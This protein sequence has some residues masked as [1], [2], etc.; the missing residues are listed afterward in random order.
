MLPTPKGVGYWLPSLRDFSEAVAKACSS[1]V[2]VPSRI[3]LMLP[4]KLAPSSLGEAEVNSPRFQPWV[5]AGEG[6]SP[7]RTKEASA[8]PPGLGHFAMLPTPKGVGYWLP[9]LRDF[10]E[11][12]AM[13]AVALCSLFVVRRSSFVADAVADAVED[14][15]EA[16]VK[17]CSLRAS[18]RRKSIAH[19]FNRG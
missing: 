11:A 6:Q 16:A 1:L 17:A 7:G 3:L 15:I 2:L 12:V 19:G 4:S 13:I 10:S 14:F 5:G 8:V 9:S 18:E